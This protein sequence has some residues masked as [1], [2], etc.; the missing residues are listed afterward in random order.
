MIDQTTLQHHIQKHIIG[1]LMY[2]KF[3]RFRDLRPPK[4][5]TNLYSYHLK[6]LQK[7]KLIEKTTEGY[8][9]TKKGILYIDRV[10]T[11]TLDVR[12][13]PKIIT[14]LLVQNGDGDILLFRRRRQ[15]YT[16]TWTLP[17]GKLHIDDRS[18][19][20][21]A[22]REA[23]EKL[24]LKN[25]TITHAGDCYIRIR[26]GEETLMTTLAHV[27]RLYSDEVKLNDYLQWV[28]PHKLHSIKL[29]PAV[30]KIVARAFFKDPYFFEEFEEKW[31]NEGEE[32]NLL[33]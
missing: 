21:A 20:E 23:D 33:Q 17:Y 11:S 22:H 1:V 9:L 5:D 7:A 6:L 28:Q 2:Q 16:N 8:T 31:G 27:F 3:A 19:L 12:S 25:Q 32:V 10:T 24:E 4:V 14:M 30:E 13:Q 26:D 15:P 18:L 29:A